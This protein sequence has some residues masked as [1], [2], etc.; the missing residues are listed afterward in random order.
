MTSGASLK[1]AR[2]TWATS[3][4]P[5]IS[6]RTLARRDFIRVPNPAAIIIT[7]VIETP[8]QSG[9]WILDFGFWIHGNWL[10]CICLIHLICNPKSKIAAR[11]THL[12]PLKSKIET[13][14]ITEAERRSQVALMYVQQ[15]S[16]QP[17]RIMAYYI[18]LT[19]QVFAQDQHT[20]AARRF[21]NANLDG[22]LASAK[23]AGS[24]L[25]LHCAVSEIFI[26]QLGMD[27]LGIDYDIIKL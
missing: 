2:K 7:S 25:D 5:A 19:D 27:G 24:K 1:A 15:Q 8:S 18:V 14:R 9:F 13:A 16:R 6:W 11:E 26:A 3:G 12:T 23:R 4:R 21:A 17:L 10:Q 22:K 20:A